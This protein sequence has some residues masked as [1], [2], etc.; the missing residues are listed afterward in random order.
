MARR[1]RGHQATDAPREGHPGE[2]RHWLYVFD[3]IQGIRIGWT[4]SRARAIAWLK[5]HA[6]G[7][8]TCDRTTRARY[9]ATG[10]G[11]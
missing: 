11:V 1:K 8:W 7:G 3:G 9:D 5:A 10:Q 2:A 4:T 6:P